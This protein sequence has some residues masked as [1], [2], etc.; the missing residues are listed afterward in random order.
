MAKPMRLP[1]PASIKV[2][3]SE[4]AR[5]VASMGRLLRAGCDLHFTNHGHTFWMEMEV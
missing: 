5:N 2:D 4:V 3:V 1:I